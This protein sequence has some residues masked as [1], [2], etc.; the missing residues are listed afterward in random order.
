M[1]RIITS[2]VTTLLIGLAAATGLMA[3]P[4]HGATD[5][6]SLVHYLT[7]PLHI[8]GFI[9]VFVTAAV[10]VFWFVARR[11]RAVKVDA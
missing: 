7:E 11:K 6:H 4:N 8:A 1:R 9:A 2:F 5:G 10:I 3:H